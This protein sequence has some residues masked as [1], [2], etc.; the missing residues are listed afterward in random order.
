MHSCVKAARGREYTVTAR[1]RPH[2][3]TLQSDSHSED[4][5]AGP[6]RIVTPLGSSRNY[7]LFSIT[8]F[9]YPLLYNLIGFILPSLLRGPNQT[10]EHARPSTPR[11]PTVAALPPPGTLKWPC[12]VEDRGHMVSDPLMHTSATV[13][14]TRH[15][16]QTR[17]AHLAHSCSARSKRS[18]PMAYPIPPARA[19]ERSPS[20]H[21]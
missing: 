14:L 13:L 1:S 16:T 4:K 10:P 18:E 6:E 17:R 20:S 5:D 12:L 9:R 15:P 21:F 2:P 19:A 8:E 3:R 7:A 11:A